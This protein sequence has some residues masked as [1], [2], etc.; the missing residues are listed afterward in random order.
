MLSFKFSNSKPQPR[1][2]AKGQFNKDLLA[3]AQAHPEY[4]QVLLLLEARLADRLREWKALSPRSSRDI[5]AA[6]ARAIEELIVLLTPPKV[7]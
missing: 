7:F 2:P 5:L 1:Q 3:E 4:R 6:E